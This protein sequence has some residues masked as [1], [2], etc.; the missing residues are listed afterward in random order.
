MVRIA[1]IAML[2]ALA[3]SA[4]GQYM[5]LEDSQGRSIK[6]VVLTKGS[7]A[8]ELARVDGQ[9]FVVSFASFSAKSQ[10]I[11]ERMKIPQLSLIVNETGR[12]PTPRVTGNQ[13]R[14]FIY[15]DGRPVIGFYPDEVETVKRGLRDTN[16]SYV[17]REA[18][19]LK[20]AG[21]IE[22]F[23]EGRFRSRKSS[24]PPLSWK[25]NFL[26]KGYPLSIP[27]IYEAKLFSNSM[28]GSDPFMPGVSYV[29]DTKSDV[30]LGSADREIAAAT[31]DPFAAPGIAHTEADRAIQVDASLA[32]ALLHFLEGIKPNEEISKLTR[33]R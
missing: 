5:E 3:C 21:V 19:A 13:Y 20:S 6:A 25:V 30:F 17:Q 26:E 2:G 27:G 9:K 18:G 15:N 33:G 7:E 1:L 16:A 10:A 14:L 32:V 23:N 28:V 29:W 24:F 4:Y 31:G 8:V 22:V 11:I 12:K